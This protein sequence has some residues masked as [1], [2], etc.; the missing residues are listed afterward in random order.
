MTKRALTFLIGYALM[1]ALYI[2]ARPLQKEETVY[3]VSGYDVTINGEVYHNA[4]LSEVSGLLTEKVLRHDEIELSHLLPDAGEEIFAGV[5]FDTRGWSAEAEID[6]VKIYESSDAALQGRT[7]THIVPCGRDYRERLLTIRLRAVSD[8]VSFDMTSPLLGEYDAVTRSVGIPVAGAFFAGGFLVLYG[9][10]SL[11][12]MMLFYFRLRKFETQVPASMMASVTGLF[13]LALIFRHRHVTA[14]AF[15]MLPLMYGYLMLLPKKMPK[16]M[17][18]KVL[19][20]LA[21]SGSAL[22]VFFFL[23]HIMD[24]VSGDHL[25]IPFLLLMI[26][27]M[28]TPVVLAYEDYVD[29]RT[30]SPSSMQLLGVVSLS[31]TVLCGSI[32]YEIDLLTGRSLGVYLRFVLPAVVALYLTSQ[33]FRYYTI[34]SE[35]HSAHSENELLYRVAYEDPLTAL[36]N[37]A[38][39][40]EKMKQL[41]ESTEPYCVISMDLDGLKA[42]NDSQGHQAGDKLIKGFA[43]ALTESFTDKYFLSR[44]GGDEFCVIMENVPETEVK[45]CLEKMEQRLIALDRKEKHINHRCS[46]GYCI[47]EDDEKT[48]HELYL[49]A[50]ERM[51]AMKQSHKAARKADMMTRADSTEVKVAQMVEETL[52]KMRGEEIKKEPQETPSANE[53]LLAAAQSATPVPPSPAQARAQTGAKTAAPKTAEQAMKALRQ[54]IENARKKNERTLQAIKQ[55]E[56]A[57]ISKDNKVKKALKALEEA[58]QQ[59][60]KPQ[61]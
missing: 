24:N 43:R 18:K 21:G 25:M 30:F 36:Y 4:E 20:L 27:A 51:Y 35:A 3:L 1:A 15:L 37:R 22:G 17:P 52:A 34:I 13:I 50:D 5:T 39:W 33:M 14:C 57:Q 40:D 49:I 61:S 12:T 2:L 11:L 59:Q 54:P 46:Y 41:A 44:I 23:L 32:F 60:N 53:A 6:G 58:Q 47:R 42:I 8:G 31:L 29:D 56:I 48:A 26:L 28:V 55:Q 10:L 9:A 19:H 16:M 38:G 7:Y 45:R